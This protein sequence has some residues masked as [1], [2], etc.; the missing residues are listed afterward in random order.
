[1]PP[2]T[3]HPCV[4][5]AITVVFALVQ[6]KDACGDALVV[7]KAMQSSTI[8]EIFIDEK[9]VRVEI[10]IGA[11]D[12]L[13]FVNVLPDAVHQKV[14]G[15]T[16]PLADRVA[17]FLESDWGVQADGE[18]LPGKVVSVVPGR[19]I[20]RDEVTGEPLIEQPDDA[21]F[22]IRLVVR[23]QLNKRPRTLT[24]RPLLEGTRVA[25]SIGFVCYHD[26]LPVNDFRYLSQEVTLDL[27]WED[28]W[29]SR[30]RHP[31]LRRQFDSP[32]AAF[33]YVEPYEVRKEIIIRPR[34]LANW[35]DLELPADG[36][37]PVTQQA[38]LKRRV[39]EFLSGKSP[40]IVDGRAVPGRLDRIHFVRR[41]LRT[42]GV[43]EPPVD[44]DV[45]S[46]TLGV[47]YVYPVEQLPNEV[48]M[49]WELFSPK[50][51]E[52]PAVTSDEAGGL[53]SQLTPA[54]P[55]LTWKNYLTNPTSSAMLTVGKPPP[56]RQW[57]VPCLSLLGVCFVCA[58]VG[59]HWWKGLTLSRYILA[60]TILG[61]VFSVVSLPYARLAIV[62]PF[63]E[64]VRLSTA[65]AKE[66]TSSLLYNVY[67]SF[68]SHDETLVYDR[69]AKSISGDLL[70][71]V[72]L[73]TRRSM[74]VK[75]QGGLRVSVKEAVVTELEPTGESARG[76]N[77]RCRWRVSGWIGHWGHVHRRVNEHSARI[78]LCDQDGV[79]KITTLE[80]LDEV[81]AVDASRQADTEDL[82][83]S[84]SFQRSQEFRAS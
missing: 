49:R 23:H 36:I 47:I 69:L 32:L 42:I 33:L 28:P 61:L 58:M 37:I 21:D 41:T 27:D 60:A 8:A 82:R 53:P 57:T 43:I 17:T 66:I 31:N 50:I 54:A 78:T 16:S 39:S 29:Y 84:S 5:A 73:E 22:V 7:S 81:S 70:S 35:I 13:A 76:K 67:R 38:E 19:R 40:V 75:N 74:E 52:V 25:A 15:K 59:W 30:F 80:M 63:A 71:D 83:R 56:L 44:L 72:Y 55:V 51:Q 24:F 34:D 2:R 62:N 11:P 48:S 46:A 18:L 65:E 26:G 20:M 3:L 79:W 14:I 6:I 64:P 9:Q 68:D 45:N 10:E 12:M 1:M 77:F 4:A